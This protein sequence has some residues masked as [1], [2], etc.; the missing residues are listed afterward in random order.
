MRTVRLAQRFNRLQATLGLV[1][2]ICLILG[3]N[4]L[5]AP[6]AADPPP[7]S[8][9]QCQGQIEPGDSAERPLDG[10]YRL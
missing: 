2:S 10:S 7:G 3:A 1:L 8:D 6:D 9:P 5:V 4:R